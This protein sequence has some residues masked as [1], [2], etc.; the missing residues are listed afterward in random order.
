MALL[1]ERLNTSGLNT[2][3]DGTSIT[4]HGFGFASEPVGDH[5]FTATHETNARGCSAKSQN[6]PYDSVGTPAWLQKHPMPTVRLTPFR[7]AAIYAAFGI[8]ALLIFDFYLPGK[9]P[10]PQLSKLQATKG[11]IEVVLTAGLIYL[12]SYYGQRQ[13]QQA[14]ERLDRFA[15]IISHDLRNPLTTLKGWIELAKEDENDAALERCEQVID[16]MHEL[17]DDLLTLARAGDVIAELSDVSLADSVE[18]SWESVDTRGAELIVDDDIS[19]QAD[20]ERLRQLLENLFRNA[21]EHGVPQV[22]VHVGVIDHGTGVYIED[23]GPGIPTDQREDVFES[24]YSTAE[25]GTGI[26]LSIV[27]EI[28]DAHDWEVH[29]TDGSDGG[30]RF[31][32]TGLE[33]T[34]G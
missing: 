9:L 14:N 3:I 17:I 30:A 16:R 13:L 11:A 15:S 22:A 32:I 27:K 5:T 8:T 34:T 31:E 20:E 19:I 23:N 12:L 25:E 26:G 7:I 1:S 29:L 4:Y 21:I 2:S 18:Q 24:G 28:C 33:F 10:E 6:E